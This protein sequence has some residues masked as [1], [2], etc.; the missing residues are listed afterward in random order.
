MI[1]VGFVVPR[2]GNFL[3][4]LAFDYMAVVRGG[5]CGDAITP[6][7]TPAEIF[8]QLEHEWGRPPT[9]VEVAA[10]HQMLSSRR[11][12]AAVT[13]GVGLGAL[14]LTHKHTHGR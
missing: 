1:A 2:S 12:E 5:V 14:Y 6:I 4:I 3:G 13:A 7:P 10:V 11:N 8:W 9:V